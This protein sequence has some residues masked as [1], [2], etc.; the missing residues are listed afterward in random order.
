MTGDA[1]QWDGTEQGFEAICEWT[2]GKPPLALSLC[3]GTHITVPT[4]YG[5]RTMLPGWW[6]VQTGPGRYFP[7]P[8]G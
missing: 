8:A 2:V 4:R 6:L 3:K 5:G 7:S 1:M